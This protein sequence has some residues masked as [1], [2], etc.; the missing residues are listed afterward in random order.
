MIL[1]WRSGSQHDERAATYSPAAAV[2]ASARHVA[3]SGVGGGL[4]VPWRLAIVR[5]VAESVGAAQ[6]FLIGSR[7]TGEAN[8]ESDCDISVVLPMWK[9]LRAARRFPSVAA[10]LSRD[11]GVPVSVNPVPRWLF[12]HA[13]HN[14]YV[15]KV[16]T[17]GRLLS[18]DAQAV[19]PGQK[20]PASGDPV[21]EKSSPLARHAEVS[22]LMSAVHTLLVGV[23]PRILLRCSLDARAEAALS[24]ARAQVAQ[25]CL[26]ARGHYVAA[27]RAVTMAEQLGLL[28]V[29]PSGVEAFIGLRGRLLRILGSHPIRG[30]GARSAARD[31]QY[32]ALS[33]LRGN[34]RF[35]VLG[36]YRGMEARLAAASLYLLQ[37]L[38][39]GQPDGYSADLARKASLLLPPG[40]RPP[41]EDYGALRDIILTEWASAQP[42]VGIVP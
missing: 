25:A 39:P 11:F 4:P 10:A 6:V 9:V 5:M 31:L 1:R 7:A 23:E 38:S 40:L 22:Y 34:R 14:L 41:C 2:A 19:S 20:W 28:V 30:S 3:A 13:R 17:E 37:S 18:A 12:G 33:A 29:G 24:K 15:L 32:V 8:P 42:L 16:R 36:H 35:Q 21:W 26:L 27:A